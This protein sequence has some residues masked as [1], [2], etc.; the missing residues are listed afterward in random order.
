MSIIILEERI[1]NNPA[2]LEPEFR[3]VTIWISD[4]TTHYVTQVGVLPLTGD[5][6]PGLLANEA[7][8]WLD[9][10]AGGLLATKAQTAEAD[11][12]QFLIDNPG[13]RAIFDLARTA[14]ETEINALVDA[15]F[16]PATGVSN[17]NKTKL[18]RLLTGNTLVS[19]RSTAAG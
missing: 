10:V 4:G 1:D 11:L 18:K 3:G 15:L 13:A 8:I 12:E 14:L 6:L 2:T 17:A 7:N 16:P 5:L 19:R 9:A